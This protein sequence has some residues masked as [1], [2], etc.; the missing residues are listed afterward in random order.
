VARVRAHMPWR[1]GALELL[2]ALRRAGVP[3]GLVTMSYRPLADAVVDAL[4]AGTFQVVVTGEEVRRG[5]P[6]PEPYLTAAARLG[7]DPASCVVVEDS[8][9]GVGSGLAA[10][11]AVVAVPH[12]VPIAAAAGVTVV[13][14]LTEVSV[15]RLGALVGAAR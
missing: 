5:K 15:D 2:H 8:P 9:S 11:C 4:P 14:S 3:R 7:V 13:T 6:D 1:P 10:G 12:E